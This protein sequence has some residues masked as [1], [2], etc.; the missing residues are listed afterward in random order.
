M[1]VENQ[2]AKNSRGPHSFSSQGGINMSL[3]P[4]VFPYVFMKTSNPNTMDTSYRT[5]VA[6]HKTITHIHSLEITIRVAHGTFS[7]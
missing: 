1:W 4:R 5:K 3:R 2:H 6:P 7:T